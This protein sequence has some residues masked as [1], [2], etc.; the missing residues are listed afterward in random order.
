MAAKP[1]KTLELHY[2][3]IQFLIIIYIIYILIKVSV[4][5]PGNS[6]NTVCMTSGKGKVV[7][8]QQAGRQA[9]SEAIC[10]CYATGQKRPG[11]VTIKEY[12]CLT[13]AHSHVYSH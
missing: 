10:S 9:G 6:A 8:Q 7:R 12:R 4:M 1:I 2:T 13:M 3:M 5:L 11:L